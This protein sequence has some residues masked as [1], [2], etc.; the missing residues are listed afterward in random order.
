MHSSS[1]SK[2]WHAPHLP[3]CPCLLCCAPPPD[4]EHHPTVPISTFIDD[5]EDQELL[6]LLPQ[7]LQ[8]EGVEDVRHHLGANQA[9]SNALCLR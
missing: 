1:A 9:R 6:E 3:S 4:L 5:M 8:V 2:S 7:L